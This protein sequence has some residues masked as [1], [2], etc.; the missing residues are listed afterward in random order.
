MSNHTE[1]DIIKYLN[2]IS[3]HLAAL[4]IMTDEEINLRYLP[5]SMGDENT[6]SCTIEAKSNSKYSM[7][8]THRGWG[9]SPASAYEDARKQQAEA[10]GKRELEAKV[11]AYRQSL[12]ESEA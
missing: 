5:R 4:K 7:I 12:L 1:L 11:E 8:Q 10:E 6:Y 9:P 2:T 3:D